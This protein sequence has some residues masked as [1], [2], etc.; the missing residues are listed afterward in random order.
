[1]A[2][3]KAQLQK[4]MCGSCRECVDACPGHAV[5]GKSWYEGAQRKELFDAFACKKAALEKAAKIGV[6]NTICGVCIASCPW[7]I[8]YTKN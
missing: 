4:N 3:E 7:T 6:K 8:E 5:T 2:S 1:M